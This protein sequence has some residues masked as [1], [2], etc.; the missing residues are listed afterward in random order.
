MLP[1]LQRD[2]LSWMEQ[3]PYS[4]ES[5]EVW[6][7]SPGPQTLELEGDLPSIYMV[8]SSSED[9]EAASM[10]FLCPYCDFLS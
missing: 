1:V 10:L 2:S 4:E 9:L 3:E 8:T 7:A 6:R 5:V